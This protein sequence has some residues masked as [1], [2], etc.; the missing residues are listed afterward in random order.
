MQL[1]KI[2]TTAHG[3]VDM[4]HKWLLQVPTMGCC[5]FAW[6]LQAPTLSKFLLWVIVV[7]CCFAHYRCKLLIWVIV[8]SWGSINWMMD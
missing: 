4:V 3:C 5:Y 7:S 1:L 8:P 2:E 6:L